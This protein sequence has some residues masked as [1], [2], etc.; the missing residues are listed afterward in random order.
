[1]HIRAPIV[2]ALASC[3]Q[4]CVWLILAVSLLGGG[5]AEAATANAGPDIVVVNS[6][7]DGTEVVALSSAGS[8]G[9]S[10]SWSRYGVVL[11]TAANPSLTL[12]PGQHPLLL[13]V[14]GTATDTVLVT[15]SDTGAATR[16]S[17][18]YPPPYGI[19]AHPDFLV[20]ARR[21]GTNDAFES[22][23]VH[24]MQVCKSYSGWDGSSSTVNWTYEMTGTAL[25]DAPGAME[26][27]VTKTSGSITSAVLRPLSRNLTP[28]VSGSQITFVIGGPTKLV[29]EIN[30]ERYRNL[31]ILANPVDT[32]VPAPGTPG[33][34]WYGAGVHNILGT[35]GRGELELLAGETL[36]LA[37]GAVVKGAVRAQ[38]APGVTVRGRGILSVKDFADDSY[39]WGIEAWRCDNFRLEGILLTGAPDNSTVL[40]DCT[41]MQVRN[42][43]VVDGR[44]WDDGIHIN[45]GKNIIID[46]CFIRTADDSVVFYG[47]NWVNYGYDSGVW[48]GVNQDVDN[49]QVTNC[50]LWSDV[51]HPMLV[52]THGMF[53]T[54]G[55]VLQ[56]I[57]FRN[58][59]VLEHRQSTYQNGVYQ[60][61]MS[62]TA[63]D[64][65]IVRDI[66]FEDVRVEHMISGQLFHAQTNINTDYSYGPGERI[67]RIVFRRVSWLGTD[68][69]EALSDFKTESAASPIDG[70]TFDP[71]GRS[72][73]TNL[74][75]KLLA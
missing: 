3:A 44:H 22:I 48:T 60:G 11:S 51:A 29:L 19:T 40:S 62:L 57:T 35:N 59:D 39:H 4:V 1:M 38:N 64:G 26:I 49:V 73:R 31:N 68:A 30:G 25:F 72:W 70:I 15:V 20:E 42:F 61:A 55:S 46:D 43:K 41:G 50:V 27:R 23:F 47:G 28:E 52:G 63:N 36:Y 34:K 53:S 54:G 65:N 37:P 33:V 71:A 45:A 66:L 56:N 14:D 13:T 69:K 74:R 8:S 7:G 67:D 12:A 10:F 2:S 32:A 75:R 58:I 21:A 5:M 24:Q 18:N 6:N 16:S 9:S 17:W